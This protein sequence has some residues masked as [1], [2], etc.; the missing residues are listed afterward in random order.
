MLKIRRTKIYIL[1]TVLS[2]QQVLS[3]TNTKRI[4]F[5]YVWFSEINLKI[6][7]S[8]QKFQAI[9][10]QEIVPWVSLLISRLQNSCVPR[11]GT[12]LQYFSHNFRIIGPGISSNG[13]GIFSIRARGT[14][15]DVGIWK[16]SVAVS[17]FVVSINNG[18]VDV[19]VVFIVGIACDCATEAAE[20]KNFRYDINNH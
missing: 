13:N 16:V 2:T 9:E 12:Y 3:N 10:L 6:Q 5:S 4:F 20:L 18:F 11:S 1:H 7:S 15:L 19:T 8:S 17:E 14:T